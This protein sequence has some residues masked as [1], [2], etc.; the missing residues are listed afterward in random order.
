MQKIGESTASANAQGEFT[1]GNPGSGVA[2][3][4]LKA[5]WLNA[6]QRELVHVVEGA[7]LTLD[8]ADD[9]QILKAIQAIQVNANTWLKLGGN[10]TT[11]AGFGI[12]DAFTKAETESAIQQRIADLVASSP[13]AL[14]TLNELA[15]ALGNDPNFAT[16]M[17]NA[18][19]SK[20]DRA[21][22]LA[23][24]GISDAYTK[25]EMD[26]ALGG[27]A[28][29]ATTLA[30]YGITDAYTKLEVD[31]LLATGGIAGSSSDLRVWATG[32][33]TIIGL[34]ANAVCVKNA[35][36]QQRILNSVSLSCDLGV[37]GAGGLDTG[38]LKADSS[39]NIWVIWNGSSG[40]RALLA[41]LS[42]TDP[43]MPPG[44]AFG[45]IVSWVPV[46]SGKL[47][48]SFFQRGRSWRY[49]P[50]S[51][52]SLL[53]MPVLVTGVGGDP[54]SGSWAVA[55][56][57]SL[58]SPYAGQIIVVMS[59]TLATSAAM[60]V[61]PNPS[62]GGYSSPTN[63]APVGLSSS[64]FLTSPTPATLVLEDSKI[65]WACNASSGRIFVHGFEFAL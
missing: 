29:K 23:G 28:G 14:N 22:N 36:G 60:V 7:G 30:G 16:T 64:N 21:S 32:T 24:Y 46:N 35:A 54:S 61:A 51:G 26:A 3:T 4:L 19:A 27:K 59:I 43:V 6:V 20:A 49:K 1:E 15:E 62:Y 33:G 8:A 40:E 47:P 13:E 58:V 44:F 11:I 45:A 50:A 63:P 56:V 38:L 39:Y 5:A 25:G 42:P 34:T 41:S 12:T 57:G 2:A 52:S 55:G 53:A 31:G 18:L 10:P 48:L 17:T 65:Y 9:S 37:S